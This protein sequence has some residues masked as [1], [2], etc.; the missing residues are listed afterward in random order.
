M[1]SFRKSYL[2]LLMIAPVSA[3]AANTCITVNGGWPNGGTTF[4]APGLATPAKGACAA[5]SGFAK[6]ATTIILQ[7]TGSGCLSTDGKVFTLN[8]S[9]ANPNWVGTGTF[10]ADY[11]R[12]CT[13]ATDCPVGNSFDFAFNGGIAATVTCTTAMLQLPST[14]D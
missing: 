4:V 3:F 13:K 6:T 5:F 14:H 1:L 9:S 7:T 2:C 11:I 8:L 12:L 10:Q